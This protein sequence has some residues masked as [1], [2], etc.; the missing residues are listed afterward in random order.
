MASDREENRHP[1]LLFQAFVTFFGGNFGGN[2]D[3]IAAAISMTITCRRFGT[4]KEHRTRHEGAILVASRPEHLA[5]SRIDEN[6]KDV[7]K[8]GVTAKRRFRTSAFCLENHGR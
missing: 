8:Q 7:F 6:H 2:F 3:A 5:I 1:A 4:N